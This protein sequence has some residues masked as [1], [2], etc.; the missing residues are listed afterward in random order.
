MSDDQLHINESSHQPVLTIAERIKYALIALVLG[1]ILV[2][3]IGFWMFPGVGIGGLYMFSSAHS[4]VGIVGNLTNIAIITFL[5]ISAVFGWFQGK[6]CIDR[7][8]G[9]IE[10]W[11]FW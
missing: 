6:Y 11:K 4:L 5:A 7:L 3:I 2:N 9:F 1:F 8:K 10:W